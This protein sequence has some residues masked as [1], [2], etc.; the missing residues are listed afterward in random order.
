MILG[1]LPPGKTAPQPKPNPKP[2]P[3]PNQEAIF[4]GGMCLV[5]SQR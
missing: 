3:N 4:L 5:A 1:Q 2:T